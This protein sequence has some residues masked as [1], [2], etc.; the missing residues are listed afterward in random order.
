MTT[1]RTPRPTSKPE[2]LAAAVKLARVHGLRKFSRAEVAEEAGV[3]SATVSYHFGQMDAMRKAVV[4][5][6][7]EREV[8]PILVDARADRGSSDLY[9]RMSAEL[10]Q[11]VAAY[12]SR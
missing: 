9:T 12:I 7:I 4:E 8:L 11:K 2:I 6:A 10:K 1:P 5:Y 3:A